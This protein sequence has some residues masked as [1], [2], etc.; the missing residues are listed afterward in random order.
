ML[1][2]SSSPFMASLLS[3]SLEPS[4]A[5]SSFLVASSFFTTFAVGFMSFPS[6]G[7]PLF[8]GLPSLLGS[9]GLSHAG[10]QCCVEPQFQHLFWSS[11]LW[12]HLQPFPLRHP[13]VVMK[14]LQG[15][16]S[17]FP[18]LPSPFPPSSI[19]LTFTSGCA[20]FCVSLL[21]L[22]LLPSR[23]AIC[24]ISAKRW[25]VNFP[26]VSFVGVESTWS[27]DLAK[28]ILKFS[29]L[30]ASKGRRTMRPK[31]LSKR[32]GSGSLT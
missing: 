10:A 23:C 27:I 28:L 24:S 29:S 11:R 30:L 6:Q 14:N 12:A 19:F 25:V 9:R 8:S 20:C 21:V 3:P 17:P 22:F 32:K 5:T 26:T 1:A 13:S 31:P 7:F 18:D 4:L 15:A 2:S 16:L